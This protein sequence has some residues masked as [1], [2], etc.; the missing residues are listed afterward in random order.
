[1]TLSESEW[2]MATKNFAR[3][4]MDISSD[5]NYEYLVCEI[6]FEDKYCALISQE[7]GRGIYDIEI[8]GVDLVES[9]V[10]RKVN[11]D[12]FLEAV[13]IAKKRLSGEIP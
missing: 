7:S 13:E 3:F 11:L 6:Y 2:T 5:L 4:S 9:L 10:C 1:M 8:A 12:V